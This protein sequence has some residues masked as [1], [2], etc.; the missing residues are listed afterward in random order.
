MQHLSQDT[1]SHFLST[2]LQ[3]EISGIQ[4]VG[5]GEWSRAFFFNAGDQAK[6][7]RLSDFDEDFVKDRFA[8]RFNA[9]GL[10]VP[11]VEEI[12][13]AF[14]GYYA[15]TPRVEGVLLDHL[16]AAGVRAALPALMRL[17][18]ALYAA[19]SAGTQGYGGFGADGNATL[20]SWRDFLNSANPDAPGSRQAG[21]RD[22]LARHPQE[23]ALY[24]QGRARL[25]E[26]IPLCPEERHL[27]HNDLLHYNVI[28]QGQ[29]VA[30]VIDWGC[31][32]WGDFLYDLAVFTTWQFYYPAMAG[33]DFVAAARD[34]FTGAGIPLP[35]F[36]ARLQCCQI[37]LLLDSL[38]YNAWKG[39]AVNLELAIRRLG[40]VMAATAPES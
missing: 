1:L 29:Q 27:V 30:A 4:P 32:L 23:S 25:D 13:T 17:F 24:Q 8:G 21:W 3:A 35:H 20:P 36:A 37:H 16:D 22:N 34:A 9:P 40:E 5:L 31:G 10:P 14:G 39:D 6:V 18:L 33:I 28:M 26:L 7:I 2:H 19:D 11:P 12:G 15:I 38:G